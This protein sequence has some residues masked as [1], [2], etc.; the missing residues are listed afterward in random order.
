MWGRTLR[1]LA[2]T[3][4]LCAALSLAACSDGDNDDGVN[5]EILYGRRD[6][7]GSRQWPV[8][9]APEQWRLCSGAHDQR[10]FHV[11]HGSDGRW[12]VCRHRRHSAGGLE[13]HGRQRHGHHGQCQR[14]QRDGELP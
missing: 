2:T 5:A 10:E 11:R 6:A 7:L 12:R 1:V 13:L 14:H 4:I 9:H 8:D 3:A